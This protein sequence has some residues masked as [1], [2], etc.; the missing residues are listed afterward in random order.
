MWLKQESWEVKFKRKAGVFVCLGCRMKYYRVSGL[1]SRNLFS[2][3][4]GG[5]KSKTKVPAR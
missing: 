1:N 5:R 2:H 3:S 4:S